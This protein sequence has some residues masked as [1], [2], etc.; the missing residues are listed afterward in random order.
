MPPPLEE[1]NAETGV[2]QML[3]PQPDTVCDV[4]GENDTTTLFGW[5][6]G[7]VDVQGD[8]VWNLWRPYECCQIKG[9]FLT[10][11]ESSE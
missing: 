4:F 3:V 1:M 6:S 10:D 2:W 7:K 5:A 9:L 11:I 8:Y